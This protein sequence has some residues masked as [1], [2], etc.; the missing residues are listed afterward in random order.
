MMANCKSF[1][2]EVKIEIK[3]EIKVEIKFRF[4]TSISALTLYQI[5]KTF[6]HL[7]ESSN[8]NK[9]KNNYYRKR[10]KH[11]R[12]IDRRLIPKETPA[13]TIDHSGHWVQIIQHTELFRN[14][15]RSFFRSKSDRR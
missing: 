1:K 2:I 8:A 3:V 6:F 5:G 10:N 7:P 11:T 13:K 9:Q 12:P 4:L 14:N 15:F